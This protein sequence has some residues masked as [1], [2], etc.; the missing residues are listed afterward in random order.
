M[1]GHG[2]R[3][4]V[5][6]RIQELEPGQSLPHFEGHSLNV[7]TSGMLKQ[8]AVLEDAMS[9]SHEDIKLINKVGPIFRR[10]KENNL[11]IYT[12]RWQNRCSN[13]VPYHMDDKGSRTG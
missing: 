6:K 11:Y 13:H 7:T 3:T 1:S 5:P 12:R 4:G 2:Q 8:C 10:I 9:T